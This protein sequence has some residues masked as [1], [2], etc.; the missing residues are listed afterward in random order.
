MAVRLYIDHNVPRAI[1]DGLRTR[2][3]DII[4]SLEDG[5]SEWDDP[6]LLDHAAELDCVLFTRDY[7][8]LQ[9]ATNRQRTNISFHGVIYAHQLRVS[10]GDCI[11]D[12]ETIA[13]AGD[14]EDLMNM[15]LFLP[16]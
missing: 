6:E 11:R 1:T 16:L 7:H 12:L 13:E 9:E 5:T 8:L 10:I 2:G 4:T 3:I 14:P 15:V